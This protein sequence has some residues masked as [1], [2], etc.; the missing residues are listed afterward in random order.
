MSAFARSSQINFM[1]KPSPSSWMI[2]GH[3]SWR[4][5]TADPGSPPSRASD[6]RRRGSGAQAPRAARAVAISRRL[7]PSARRRLISSCL[8]TVNTLRAIQLSRSCSATTGT[9]LWGQRPKPGFCGGRG[10][11]TAADGPGV[12]NRDDPDA[13]LPRENRPICSDIAVPLLEPGDG[14]KDTSLRVEKRLRPVVP[15]GRTRGG[16]ITPKSGGPIPTK[17]GGSNHSKS[18][19]GRGRK[20]ARRGRAG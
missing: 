3:S 18:C 10:Q 11:R 8:S 15:L 2:T 19:T 17:S 13:K 16:S 9:G 7:R 14:S 20:C 5:H 1:G 6:A 4:H 12:T